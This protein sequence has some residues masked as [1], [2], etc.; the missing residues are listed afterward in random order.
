MRYSSLLLL[1]LAACG[2]RV[3]SNEVTYVGG[4]DAGPSGAIAVMVPTAGN[5]AHGTVTFTA[6]SGGIRVH[7]E[8]DGLF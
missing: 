5:A 2:N 7:A 1:A 4:D 3:T 8:I 6:E